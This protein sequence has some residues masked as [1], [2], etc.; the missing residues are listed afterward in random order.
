MN[1]STSPGFLLLWT[2]LDFCRNNLYPKILIFISL[3]FQGVLTI[4]SSAF[5]FD[6]ILLTFDVWYIPRAVLRMSIQI[7]LYDGNLL[8][9]VSLD[10]HNDVHNVVDLTTNEFCVF[11]LSF[12]HRK[13]TSAV[14]HR[15]L[16]VSENR[17]IDPLK[18]F[19]DLFSYY[20]L[21]ILRYRPAEVVSIVW[22]MWHVCRIY[23]IRPNELHWVLHVLGQ[24]KI[25]TICYT[26]YWPEVY[27]LIRNKT[28]GCIGAGKSAY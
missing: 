6:C 26:K 5:C 23:K 16:A 17:T 13:V 20:P 18:E 25:K 3:T 14:M 28:V 12:L 24:N 1:N 22:R 10:V 4:V 9:T 15:Y 11:I 2:V 8:C 7:C 27:F 19:V 21:L